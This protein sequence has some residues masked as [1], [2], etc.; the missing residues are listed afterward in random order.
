MIELKIKKTNEKA[1]IPQIDPTNSI[2]FG[3]VQIGTG[4]GKDGRIIIEY[5]AGLSIEIPSGYVGVLSPM[6]NMYINSLLMPTSI[7]TMTEGWNDIIC[8]FKINTDSIPS[9]YEE[10]EQFC[11]LVL[12]K[13]D[14]FSLSEVVEVEIAKSELDSQIEDEGQVPE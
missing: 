3:C 7:V 10:G 6:D 14:S 4:V 2:T 1:I 11:K 9:I 5:R 12:V 8:R 13:A